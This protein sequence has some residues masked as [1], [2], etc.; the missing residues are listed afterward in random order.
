[1]PRYKEKWV[2]GKGFVDQKFQVFYT[3]GFSEDKSKLKSII[4]EAP[5]ARWA[6]ELA[7]LEL[8]KGAVLWNKKTKI[9][10]E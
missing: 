9:I 7:P 4:I 2:K 6:H 3:I 1:M 5:N 10:K 8:P